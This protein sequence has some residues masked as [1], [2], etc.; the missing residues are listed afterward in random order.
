MGR[1][2]ENP[3]IKVVATPFNV[4]E[5]VKGM[6]KERAGTLEAISSISAVSEETAASSSN[7]F[8]IAESQKETVSLLTKASDELKVNMEELKVA[9]SVFKTTE[10]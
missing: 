7:V 10:E 2:N 5:K 6:D 3:K 9:V 4:K 8:S 1:S